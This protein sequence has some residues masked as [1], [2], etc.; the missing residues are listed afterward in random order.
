MQTT[1]N[2]W[3]LL[4]RDLESE[5][6]NAKAEEYHEVAKR[7]LASSRQL[8]RADSPRL[9]DATEIAGDIC[10]AAGHPDEAAANYEEALE[11]SNRLGI[12]SSSARLAAKLALHF[13][14][15]GDTDK[16]REKYDEAQL[17][18]ES[19]GDHSSLT[20]LLNQAGSLCRRSE[21]LE[22][23]GRYY[24]RAMDIATTMHGDNH[25]EVAIAAN[26]LGVNCTDAHDFVQAES[27]HMRA[28]AIREKS[29]GAVHPDVAQSMANLAVVYHAM[30]KS[31]K[32]CAYYQGALSTYSRFRPGDDP[33]V[34]EVQENFN[35]L[36]TRMGVR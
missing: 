34:L 26:N 7:F 1:A 18:Y 30:G 16:A 25:P 35:A 6:Q 22:A 2:L 27:L 11:R 15:T 29:Y 8:L 13:D 12:K 5:R 23:A 20:M 33:E 36:L 9:C 3:E 31:D 10:Q 14:Q 4:C 24:Q 28:L 21:D 19:A 17:Q 32:A